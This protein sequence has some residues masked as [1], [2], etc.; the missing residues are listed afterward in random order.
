[1][2]ESEVA[3]GNLSSI[4]AKHYN[5]LEESGKDA[6]TT[7]RIYYLRN[8]NNWI[9]SMLIGE[10]LQKVQE[11]N[12]HDGK[13]SVLDIGAGKGGDLLKWKKGRI[14]H[15]VCAD[16]A[17][18]SLQHCQQR[19]R[20]IKRSS[21]RFGDPEPF[22][23]EFIPADC[24]KIRLKDHYQDPNIL[25]DLVS[26]QFT[27]HYCFESESQAERMIQNISECLRPGGYFIGTTPDAYDIVRRIQ[28]SEDL[29]F[30]SDIFS[31]KFESKDKFP[32]FGARYTFYLEGVV[33]C[34]EFLVYFPLFEYLAKQHGLTLVYKKRFEDMF[35]EY[36][37]T[38]RGRFLLRRLPALESFPPYDDKKLMG[39]EKNYEFAQKK[40]EEIEAEEK[41]KNRP[42]AVKLGTLSQAEW[43]VAT[44]YIA[45]AFRKDLPKA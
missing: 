27:F 21:K 10:Y 40:R 19:Y 12:R 28:N 18:T 36:E 15:L 6:R 39:E 20:D 43:E 4:V 16:I 29:Q 17:E 2:A 24:T 11:T 32:L 37:K 13:I 33:D 7:C 42:S 14:N 26:C 5:E 22:T 31:I 45:F 1:M 34:P 38:D 3:E 30:G 25:F 23:V 35:N 8:F 44:L 9:K 41:Q